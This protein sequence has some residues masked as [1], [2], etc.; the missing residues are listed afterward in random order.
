LYVSLRCVI[1]A[2]TGFMMDVQ[3]LAQMLGAALVPGKANMY[4]TLYSHNST[5][6]GL[7][8]ARDLKMAQLVMAKSGGIYGDDTL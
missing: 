3:Q 2:I 6:E 7:S 8:L 4:F 1:Y 5:A